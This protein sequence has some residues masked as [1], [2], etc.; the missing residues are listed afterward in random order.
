MFSEHWSNCALHSGPARWPRR[1]DCGGISVG[2]QSG[3]WWN[4]WG[5]TL[6]GIAR[7]EARLWQARSIWL[8]ESHASPLRLTRPTGGV[9]GST[10]APPQRGRQR[11]KE[12]DRMEALPPDPRMP[13]SA[14]LGETHSPASSRKKLA[15]QSPFPDEAGPGKWVSMGFVRF[16]HEALPLTIGGDPDPTEPGQSHRDPM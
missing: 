8:R 4:R 14:P 1:C 3:A 11:S 15:G 10:S 6:A 12:T 7:N 13:P 5:Y 16:F 2:R 9:E